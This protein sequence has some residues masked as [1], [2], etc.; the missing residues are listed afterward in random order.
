MLWLPLGAILLAYWAAQLI[1]NGLS[2]RPREGATNAL[3]FGLHLREPVAV[4]TAVFG[5]LP[6]IWLQARWYTPFESHW[7][8]VIAALVYVSHFVVIPLTALILFFRNRSRFR[9][10]IGC[11]LLLAVIGIVTYVIYPMAPP[12]LASQLGIVGQVH[13]ISAIGWDYLHLSVVGNLLGGSQMA[14]NPVAAMPSLHAASAAL[15]AIFFWGVAPWWA[16]WLLAVYPIAMGVTLVYTGE[17]YVVD[18]LAGWLAAAAAVG[19]VAL[20]R[21]IRNGRA[22]AALS[23]ASPRNANTEK[24]RA[25]SDR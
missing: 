22:G 5:S 14:S 19:G 24:V 1:N 25:V 3:G 4:D 11:V 8:D 10:W 17:H 12:W 6:T 23:S 13:R 16:R 2:A 20:Y 15:L 9:S 21:R 7:Y 18:V